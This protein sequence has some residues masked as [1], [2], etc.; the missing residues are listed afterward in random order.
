MHYKKVMTCIIRSNIVGGIYVGYPGI[1][2]VALKD[3]IPQN[4][5]QISYPHST[6]SI[7]VMSG[8]FFFGLLK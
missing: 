5:P 4:P 1:T 6:H 7:P 3:R 8:G 2:H